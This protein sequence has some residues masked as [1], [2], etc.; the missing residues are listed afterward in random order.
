M[1]LLVTLCHGKE[2]GA[3]LP[4]LQSG[5][6]MGRQAT[7]CGSTSNPQ[8]VGRGPG[9]WRSTRTWSI[10]RLPTP[11]WWRLTHALANF[12]GRHLQPSAGTLQLLWASF[13]SWSLGWISNVTTTKSTSSHFRK[14]RMRYY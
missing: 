10:T 4:E 5:L 13:P 8:A 2:A 3:Q 12:D 1:T 6:S 11:M 9:A 7:S 14:L